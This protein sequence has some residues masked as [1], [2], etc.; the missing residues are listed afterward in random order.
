MTSVNSLINE[1]LEEYVKENQTSLEKY[2]KI[3]GEV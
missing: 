1:I 2:K 3:W